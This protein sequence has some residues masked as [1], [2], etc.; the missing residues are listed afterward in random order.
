MGSFVWI[1]FVFGSGGRRVRDNIDRAGLFDEEGDRL[2]DFS[3]RS[4]FLGGLGTA[5]SGWWTHVALVRDR[6]LERALA[7]AQSGFW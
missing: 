5:G 1:G 2:P 4:W 6:L 3:E 7:F